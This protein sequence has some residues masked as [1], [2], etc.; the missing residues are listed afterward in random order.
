MQNTQVNTHGSSVRVN[1]PYHIVITESQAH[2]PLVNCLWG[3]IDTQNLVAW[4]NRNSPKSVQ[5]GKYTKVYIFWL[6]NYL[7]AFLNIQHQHV[8]KFQTALYMSPMSCLSKEQCGV[9]SVQKYLSEVLDCSEAISKL[10]K[11]LFGELGTCH[12]PSEANLDKTFPASI[13]EK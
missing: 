5:Q 9:I 6:W 10:Q 12:D 11:A 8:T 2:C 3:Q 4:G 7:H 13:R 1:F